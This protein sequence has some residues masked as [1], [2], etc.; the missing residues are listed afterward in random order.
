VFSQTRKETENRGP[1]YILLTA[2]PLLASVR[3]SMFT[4]VDQQP[5]LIPFTFPSISQLHDGESKT[6]DPQRLL[7]VSCTS[8]Q[9]SCLA[10][11]GVSGAMSPSFGVEE[12][13]MRGAV[14][15][16]KDGSLFVFHGTQAIFP[17]VLT[18]L[19][20]RSRVVSGVTAEQVEA[21]RTR[22][23]FDEDEADKLK[24]MLKRKLIKEKGI[25]ERSQ[26]ISPTQT[27][28]TTPPA[29]RSEVDPDLHKKGTQNSLL[30]ATNSPSFTPRS[31]SGPVSPPIGLDS[32]ESHCF[33]LRCHVVPLHSGSG[34]SVTGLQ[35][36][37]N[38]ALVAVLQETGYSFPIFTAP[39]L[40]ILCLVICQCSRS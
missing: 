3:P 22:V 40:T 34:Q 30:S 39:T 16:C 33:G 13:V 12:T 5:V 32:H 9:L 10:S 38:N 28:N 7:E 37:D 36:L 26:A 25:P 18:D 14:L 6:L 35:L 31:I 23:D 20:A 27:E 17:K 15:G 8:S 2:Q 11:W 19:T 1:I 29:P 4:D 21:P 24:E